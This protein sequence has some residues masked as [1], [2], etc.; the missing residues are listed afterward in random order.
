MHCLVTAVKHVNNILA[1]ARQPPIRT[2]EELLG[3]MFF[4][5]SSP[6]LYNEDP[7]LAEMN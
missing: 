1:I 6:R 2:I 7:R 3:A 5:G 4:V